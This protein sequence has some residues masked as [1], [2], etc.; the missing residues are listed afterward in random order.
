MNESVCLLINLTGSSLILLMSVLA[1]RYRS[2]RGL[3]TTSVSG[4]YM[5]AALFLGIGPISYYLSY[6]TWELLTPKIVSFYLAQVMPFL[7]GGFLLVFLR[8]FF[9]RKKVS[10][11]THDVELQGEPNFIKYVIFFFILSLIGYFLAQ[12]DIAHSGVGTFFPVFR[13]FL[14]PS[15]ILAVYQV[16]LSNKLTII[17]ACIVLILGFYFTLTSIWRSQL[18]LFM[19]SVAIGLLKRSLKYGFPILIG[20]LV[21]IL[22]ILPFQHLKK[23]EYQKVKSDLSGN[24]FRTLDLGFEQRLNFAALFFAERINY[25]REI[26]YIQHAIDK[27]WLPSRKGETYQELFLQVIPRS[28]WPDKPS[29][30]FFTNYYL[31]RR[32]GLVS[33]DDYYTS[34]GVN[35]YAEFI[36]NLSY[37]FL[38]FFVPLLFS[39][40]NWIDNQIK[41]WYSN[42]VIKWIV[43]TTMFF[44]AFEMVGI[45]NV[46]TYIIWMLLV[47]K[48]SEYIFRMKWKRGTQPFAGDM[49]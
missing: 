39:L 12:T 36:F 44:V 14:Y 35:V 22:L 18:I 42:S 23:V 25:G 3:L 11:Q 48:L 46:S 21:F 13:L 27:K 29:F 26:A 19:G 17:I 37:P 43:S 7:T 15:I 5:S 9:Q 8:D 45:V 33:E 38:V 32:V 47:A 2:K 41:G 49:A 4:L 34:W 24:F 10:E 16:R 31:P 28:I 6:F 20:G 40:F 1:I 30:N